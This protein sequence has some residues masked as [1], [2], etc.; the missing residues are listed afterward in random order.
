VSE[1][2]AE[3]GILEDVLDLGAVPVPVLDHGGPLIGGDVEVGHDALGSDRR[4][5][6]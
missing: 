5:L 2:A 3:L 4:A 6:E 1:R